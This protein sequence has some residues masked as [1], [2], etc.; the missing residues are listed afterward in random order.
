[1]T[2]STPVSSDSSCLDGFIQTF[3]KVSQSSKSIAK[4]AIVFAA[5]A[6][7]IASTV[8]GM[9]VVNNPNALSF[10]DWHWQQLTFCAAHAGIVVI[11]AITACFF[12]CV[13]S[14]ISE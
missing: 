1:M 7:I 9:M 10:A 3:P 4:V 14:R 6:L 11:S 2:K 5:V 12:S 8:C 13:H